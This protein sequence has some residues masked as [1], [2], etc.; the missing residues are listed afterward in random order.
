MDKSLID[1][2]RNS[3]DIVEVVQSYLPLKHAG[4]NWRGICPFHQ[5]TRPSLYVS[6]S[7][8]MYKCFVCG[9]GGNVFTFV[10][11]YERVGFI[12]AVKKLAL[13]AGIMLPE[14]ERTKTVSTKRDQLLLI[15]RTAMDF[16]GE[17]LF[18]H[19]K[20]V[21]EYLEK[22][23]IS[24]QTAKDLSL[25]YALNSDKA[26]LNHLMKEGHAVALLKESGLFGNYSGGMVDLFRDRLMFPIHDNVGEVI[27]FGGRVLAG[28][29]VSKY[30]NSPGTELYTKGKELY[31][32]HKTKYNISKK[33]HSIISEG[34]FDFLRLY[35]S[36]FNNAVATLGTA[37]TEDQIYLLNRYSRRVYMLYDGDAAGINNAVRG[38]LLCLAKGMEAYVVEL[39]GTEDPDTYI[40]KEGAD[41]M[42][43]RI[44]AAKP[45]TVFMAGSD[46]LKNKV[47][48]RIDQLLDAIRGISDPV[49]RE[50]AVKDV[51]ESFQ[52][53]TSA[54]NSKLRR[55]AR[56]PMEPEQTAPPPQTSLPSLENMEER[57]LLVLALKDKNHYLTLASELS[58]DYFNNR[59]C[60]ELFRYLDKHVTPD[61]IEEPATLLDNVENKDIRDTLAD[62]LFDDL[63]NMRFE[64]A[65]IQVKIRKMQRDVDDLDR[66]ILAEPHDL[67]LIKRKEELVRAYRLMTRKVVNKVRF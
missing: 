27:A 14:Y 51:S 33:D 45:L 57:H 34:Y 23:Q 35:E 16:F 65:L 13:R 2:V 49:M 53:S 1:Q 15:Y 43:E 26:L 61:A 20:Q 31:G 12:E 30:M 52:I 29:A 17:N 11:D 21:L 32:L 8:Q 19:G 56:R 6:Q 64:D 54:L 62:F 9:K 59:Q 63:Q 42:R 10:Q 58:E 66:K 55:G 24:P 36:G 67:E 18:K 47:P 48:E 7:K 37:L 4:A 44:G 39:P 50:L 40:L 38:G 3:N 5:D 46:S 22:R 60:R 25:G 28:E 41:A